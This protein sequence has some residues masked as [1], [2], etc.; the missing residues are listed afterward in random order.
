MFRIRQP[1]PRWMEL[2]LG[3]VPFVVLGLLWWLTTLGAPEE[4]VVPISILPSPG[5]VWDGLPT[6]WHD[7]ALL[8]NVGVSLGRVVK[9]FGFG[10]VVALPTGI[11]MGTFTPIRSLFGAASMALGYLPIVALVPLTIA[12]FKIGEAQ[13]VFFLAFATFVYILPLIVKAVSEV[14][15]HFLQTAWTLGATRFQT[16]TRVLVPIALPDIWDGLRLSFGVGWTW[17][18]VAEMVGANDGLGYL[19]LLAQRRGQLEHV[20]PVLMV[21]T[22]LAFATDRVFVVVGNLLFPHKVTQ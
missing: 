14:P 5:E 4:R 12:I 7:K 19:I 17:I 10:L 1:I 15:E 22:V 3:A 9:G 21:I 8:R 16:V 18:L 6:L 20:Y 13:K 11:A 2:C